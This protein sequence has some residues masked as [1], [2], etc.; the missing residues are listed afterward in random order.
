ME[1]S[2]TFQ[3]KILRCAK[4]ISDYNLY[5]A[6][7]EWS[8]IDPIIIEDRK[9]LRSMP[10]WKERLDP[11]NHQIN[12]LINFCRRLP[13]TLIADD[14]G[15]GKTIS[16]GLI[17]SE[18]ISRGRI[19]K[20]LIV[21][22]KILLPQWREE[23]V[24]KFYI[25]SEIVIG[26]DISKIKKTIGL[27]VILTTYS[28]SRLHFSDLE[29]IGFEM[30]ILD[31]AHKLRNLC[32]VQESPKIA[33]IFNQAFENRAFK[34]VLMLTATPIQNRLWDIYSLI[35][36][37]TSARGVENPFGTEG[38][39]AKEY[40]S[41]ERSKARK[42]R[43]DKQEKFRSIVY[44]YIS[45]IR[46]NQVNLFFPDRIVKLVKVDRFPSEVR[47]F[48]LLSKK[49]KNLHKFAQIS[50]LQACVSS[51]HAL[52]KE[53]ENMA[54][55]GTV[56]DEFAIEVRSVIEEDDVSAK[57]QGLGA[58]IDD[59][60]IE[61]PKEWRV[62]IFTCRRETQSIIYDYLIRKG[63]ACGVINGDSADRNQ[64]VVKEF[65]NQFITMHVIISTEAGSEGLNLQVANV[66]VNY[67]LPWNPM[68]VEQRIGRLQRLSSNHAKVTVMNIIL[69]DTFEEFIVGRLMEKIQ[70]A[71]HAVGNIE[72]LLQPLGID[73]E[74][75]DSSFEQKIKD[76]VLTSLS[77]KDIEQAV[78]MEENNILEAKRQL[79]ENE[80]NINQLLGDGS[81]FIYQGPRFP[82]LQPSKYSMDSLAFTKEALLHFDNKNGKEDE[83]NAGYVGGVKQSRDYSPGTINFDRLVSQTIEN[84]L[85]L[86][87]DLDIE[88]YQRNEQVCKEWATKFGGVYQSISIKDTQRRYVGSALL[89]VRVTVAYDSYEKLI[90]VECNEFSSDDT[91]ELDDISPLGQIINSP[92]ELRISTNHLISEA[93]KDESVSEFSRFYSERLEEELKYIQNNEAKKIKLL[94]D[95]TPRINIMLVGLQGALRRVNKVVVQYSLGESEIYLSDLA[96]CSSE[97]RIL[98]QPSFKICEVSS[99]KVPIDCFDK[100]DI[101]G[102]LVIKDLLFKSETSGRRA[103]QG[104]SVICETTGKKVIVDEVVKSD[105]SHKYIARNDVKTSA[106]SGKRA[107]PEYFGMCDFTLEDV[108]LSELAVSQYSR[109]HY[110][111]DEQRTS[112]ISGKSGHK[113]EFVECSITL[114][115]MFIEECEK[116]E[117]SGKIVM[118]GLLEI[119]SVSGKKALPIEMD[120]SAVSGKVALKKYFVISS[121][122]EAHLLEQEAI[123][124]SAGKFCS[125]EE[126][127]ACC[128]SGKQ[129]HIDD[130]RICKL[131]GLRMHYK[132]INSRGMSEILCDLLDGVNTRTDK[133][134]LWNSI[135]P[136]IAG[137][138]DPNSSKIVNAVISPD[139]KKIALRIV[140][141]KWF[142]MSVHY[143]GLFFS[144]LD[145]L[146]IGQIIHVK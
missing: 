64:E 93:M 55:N 99:R 78:D 131:T 59:L 63:C 49:I 74:D 71:C 107:E 37:L 136:H 14:V 28:T 46:R 88:L 90:N 43:P 87:Q 129:Y 4:S 70:L 56:S 76:L 7:L 47:L 102:K 94:D 58:L 83:I 1:S 77:G 12:N 34:Y 10:Q 66:L 51:S 25:P 89:R 26:S 82:R 119:C 97:N 122:S 142:G 6:G 30:L 144:L 140:T 18:M 11:Y 101:S 38:N 24:S 54:R 121:L 29:K 13:V 108:L 143:H 134:E 141:R 125:P 120:K 135:V 127:K 91:I 115:P 9:D 42:L 20:I 39:F 44:S 33:K 67:D 16:A 117:V 62:V 138:R 100:C 103:L 123:R 50:L 113:S 27:Q 36:L 95:L 53:L 75:D 86:V 112:A 105:I 92:D 85:H 60:I 31:E 104:Y 35:Q 139:Y 96:L 137:L 130:L 84:A 132:Y 114:Q 79:E 118:P 133:S 17:I 128:W 111:I 15:L 32:G 146:R 109:K 22:P 23:L 61:N 41:D 72:S 73:D 52:A 145:N 69:K 2:T 116:S 65:N 81:D 106:V 98:K 19:S 8:L 110:R 3:A 5:F 124:S 21:S 68:I 80:E 45:R 40:I 48:N 126:T 57:L